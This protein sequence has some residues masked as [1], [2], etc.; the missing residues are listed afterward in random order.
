MNVHGRVLLLTNAA[1]A[2]CVCPL[3]LQASH[4]QLAEV[5]AQLESLQQQPGGNS[6]G[7]L[8]AATEQQQKRGS[9]AADADLAAR[10][11]SLEAQQQELRE[12]AQRLEAAQQQLATADGSSVSLDSQ[13]SSMRDRSVMLAA[14]HRRWPTK[15]WMHCAAPRPVMHTLCCAEM[16]CVCVLLV[17]CR[18]QQFEEQLN[19]A[20]RRFAPGQLG[21]RPTPDGSA[22]GTASDPG[23]KVRPGPYPAHGWLHGFRAASTRG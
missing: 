15:H 11:A 2:V 19:A 18:I 20:I 16:V 4:D 12:L 21:S 14:Q 7:V 3:V 1:I 17:L 6:S 13:P 22:P 23:N 5:R 8:G 9:D 10:I